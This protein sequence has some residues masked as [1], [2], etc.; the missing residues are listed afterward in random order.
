MI[1]ADSGGNRI[2]LDQLNKFM[3]NKVIHCIPAEKFT[4]AFIEFTLENFDRTQH[5]FIVRR[6]TSYEV[7]S[8]P[9]VELI[10]S[11]ASW[12]KLFY[13]YFA[14]LQRA[15]KIIIHSLFDNKLTLLLALQPW[16]LSKCVWVIWG[17]D[18][19]SSI[20]PT[21]TPKELLIY[22]FRSFVI[23]RLGGIV[24]LIEGDYEIAREHF[25]T[26]AKYYCSFVYPSN[27]AHLQSNHLVQRD[28]INI[29]VGNSADPS[30]HHIDAL[31]RLARLNLEKIY[32]IA[33]LSYG[34][35]AY[36]EKVIAHGEK[37]FGKRFRAIEHFMQSVEY[38][39]LLSEI[40]IAIFNHN[41]QQGIGNII[42]LLNFGKKVY[43][44]NNIT[45]WN[46]FI[47]NKI[48]LFDIEQLDLTPISETD[49][50]NNQQRIS[51]YFNSE[52]LKNELENLFSTS[53]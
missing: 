41:R 32:V 33:P 39:S 9:E 34:N 16:L 31:E 4:E 29:L 49:K 28:Y 13:S 52:N 21:R 8:R 43:I 15:D 2:K 25:H 30:N 26:K 53:C 35:R 19:Y 36:A 18:L 14:P 10:P 50:Q 12:L 5:S 40:D 22:I 24:S 17:G 11:Q 51:N 37:L 44:R 6:H 42:T 23:R 48:K 20:V 3:T 27:I 45:P 1:H 7:K 46:F 47:K 38:A